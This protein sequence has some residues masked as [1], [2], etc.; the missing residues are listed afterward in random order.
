MPSSVGF[1]LSVVASAQGFVAY[2]ARSA[3]GNE[4]R[5][6]K[7]QILLLF[8]T[9]VPQSPCTSGSIPVLSFL[10]AETPAKGRIRNP[11]GR[12]PASNIKKWAAIFSFGIIHEKTVVDH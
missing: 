10:P 2:V 7:C 3:A 5:T 11:D 6:P 12:G 9:I 4:T 1:V 8:L